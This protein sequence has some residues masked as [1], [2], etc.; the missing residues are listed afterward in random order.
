MIG[1]DLV[2]IS[3]IER[4]IKRGGIKFINRFTLNSNL[5]FELVNQ[6]SRVAGMWAAKEA[7]YKALS[8]RGISLSQIRVEYSTN[9]PEIRL[10]GFEDCKVDVSISHD[11]EYAIAVALVKKM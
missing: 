5:P 1:C 4:A 6:Y 10:L 9:R 8:T 3:R 2:K 11:G 7:A